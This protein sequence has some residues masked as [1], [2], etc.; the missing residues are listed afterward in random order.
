MEENSKVVDKPKEKV[1]FF[2]SIEFWILAAF[3]GW[4]VAFLIRFGIL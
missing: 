1:P 2:E 4:I 3:I